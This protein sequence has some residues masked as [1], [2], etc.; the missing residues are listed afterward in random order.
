MHFLVAINTNSHTDGLVSANLVV[1][2]F[3][4]VAN[5]QTSTLQGAMGLVSINDLLGQGSPN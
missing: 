5:P 2:L 3:V 4:I 1:V